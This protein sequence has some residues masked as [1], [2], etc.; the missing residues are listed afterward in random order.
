M[1]PK[2]VPVIYFGGNQLRFQ[3][4]A[5]IW[6]NLLGKIFATTKLVV[7]L[8]NILSYWADQYGSIDTSNTNICPLVNILWQNILGQLQVALHSLALLTTLP[9]R[10][11]YCE[12]SGGLIL[13]C[14]R[15]RKM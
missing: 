5:Q 2:W 13:Y 4:S 7:P 12:H 10:D 3:I 14:S 11:F 8:L 6:I 9:N 15:I 1:A